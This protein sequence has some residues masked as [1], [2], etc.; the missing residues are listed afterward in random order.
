MQNSPKELWRAKFSYMHGSN[1]LINILS[2]TL[3]RGVH[4]FHIFLC[5]L[6]FIYS[7]S[8]KRVF[9]VNFHLKFTPHAYLYFSRTIDFKCI[10][11]Q[12]AKVHSAAGNYRFHC[13]H[14]YVHLIFMWQIWRRG[15]LSAFK[16]VLAAEV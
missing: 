5:F 8:K 6:L 13:Q 11:V 4:H 12:S 16:S 14:M 10:F 15:T 9:L 1:S 2:S 7:F 3:L